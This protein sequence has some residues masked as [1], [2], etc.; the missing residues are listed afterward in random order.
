MTETRVTT[1]T[2]EST[3]HGTETTSSSRSQTRCPECDGRIAY[4]E[5]HGE[6]ACEECGLILEEDEIDRGPEWRSFDGADGEDRSRVGAPASEL[7]HDRG[8]STTIGWQDKDAYGNSLSSRKRAQIQRL[9]TW[10]ERFR[11]K[12]AQERNLRQAFGEIERMASALGLPQSCRETASVLYRRAVDEELLPGRSIEAMTTASLYAAARQ[13]DTPRTLDTVASVS[14][15]DRLPIQ[16]GYRYLAT[17]L[18]LEMKPADPTQYLRQY[19]S[20]LD[21]SDEAE[22][23]AREILDTAKARGA[24][25]GKSPAGIAAAAIYAAARL[26]NERLTQET[27]SEVSSVSEVTVRNR[28]QEL[29]EIYG[30]HGDDG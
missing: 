17:E 18:G 11:T 25:S 27:V 3:R 8:L 14:R 21:V 29:L 6:R 30:E 24:H 15:V 26:T 19:A 22:R 10:D 4:D 7:M 23:V 2:R 5:E 9:R 28:Y 16:R 12:D 13:H 1:E 20:K